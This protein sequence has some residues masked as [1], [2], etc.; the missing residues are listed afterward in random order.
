MEEDRDFRFNA[1]SHIFI[2]PMDGLTHSP[3]REAMMPPFG[4][5]SACAYII[6]PLV[7]FGVAFVGAKR[8]SKAFPPRNQFE[9]FTIRL[10]RINNASHFENHRSSVRLKCEKKKNDGKTSSC[11]C[12]NAR[13]RDNER[14]ATAAEHARSLSL[15][16]VIGEIDENP[17]F[18]I[19][20][21]ISFL[22]SCSR[23]FISLAESY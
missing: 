13:R 14:R 11:G 19:H 3:D 8:F 1:R 9:N 4:R 2:Q 12:A 6:A 23:S 20:S 17:F 15:S 5:K 7:H 10:M 18:V 16:L 22:F 21:R